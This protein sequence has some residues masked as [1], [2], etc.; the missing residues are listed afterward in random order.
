MEQ[1]LYLDNKESTRKL[2]LSNL[3]KLNDKQPIE[4]LKFL[5]KT[6]NIL[7][8]INEIANPNTRKNSYICVVSALK[9]QKG[10][11]KYYELYHK[12]MMEINALLNDTPFKSEK[13]KEKCETPYS[14]LN[15]RRDYL[16]SLV[17]LDNPT[18]E[19]MNNLEMLLVVCLYTMLP[20]RRNLDYTEM[21]KGGENKY[22][23]GKFTFNIYKTSDTYHTQVVQVPELIQK[24]IETRQQLVPSEYLFE[25]L[26]SSKMSK[27]IKK[28]F[29]MDIGSSAIRNIYLTEKYSQSQKELKQDCKDMGTS[30]NVAQKTYIKQSE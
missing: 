9:N 2:Y 11:K 1:T 14:K 12:Y 24:I 10:Y 30:M 26:T 18:M 21:K 16:L 6:E 19:Q 8:Q 27:L 22:E 28:S 5:K 25:N 20:P 15:E 3:R 23:D 4:N 7:K 17:D 13:T 29:D